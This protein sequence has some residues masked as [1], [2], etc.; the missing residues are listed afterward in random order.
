MWFFS[1]P[2][3]FL[4]SDP[5]L[6]AAQKHVYLWLGT[7][8]DGRPIPWRL[9]SRQGNGGTYRDAAGQEKTGALFL[10]CGMT[11]GTYRPGNEIRENFTIPF[12]AE[13]NAQEPEN[14]ADVWR[15]SDVR[16]WCAKF[17]QDCLS[18]GE[19]A[20]LLATYKS[21]GVYQVC[22]Y[23]QQP[24]I[25]AALGILDGD[26]VFFL[27]DEEAENTAYGFTIKSNR[28]AGKEWWTRT[29]EKTDAALGYRVASIVITNSGGLLSAPISPNT[30]MYARPAMN[31]DS[32]QVLMI[33]AAGME[34]PER[35][36][37]VP[38][39]RGPR[40]W[41]LT[42]LDPALSGLSLGPVRQEGKE[43]AVPYENAPF[44]EGLYL[45]AMALD[46]KGR[47][48][49][50]GAVSRLESPAGEAV[51]AGLPPKTQ[52]FLFPERRNG[53]KQTDYAG[54]PIPLVNT[55]E[56]R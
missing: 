40:E 37:K 28:T 26:R 7:L 46:Q 30:S 19:R 11:L 21:D 15:E 49:C 4:G 17:E 44:G 2:S 20:A 50:Y 45:S 54:S 6:K 52:V 41:K 56:N 10:L 27:S 18:E 12:H 16:A 39:L 47:M 34:K 53:P 38:P 29:Y 3:L 35:L 48:V 5:R 24:P 43:L 51:F 23:P 1:A 36:T 42:L 55:A 22:W 9:L 14:P 32:R 31:L 8:P 33:S 13:K 25:P